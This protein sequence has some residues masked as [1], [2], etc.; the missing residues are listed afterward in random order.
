[1]R[2]RT[3]RRSARPLTLFIVLTGLKYEALWE[4]TAPVNFVL[5]VIYMEINEL[6][7]NMPIFMPF[8]SEWSAENRLCN[9]L[10]ISE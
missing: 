5:I 9:A 2:W 4:R 10:V 6:A 3:N 7:E 1:M 8:E